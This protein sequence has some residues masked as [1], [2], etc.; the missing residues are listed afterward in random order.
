MVKTPIR[1]LLIAGLF[2]T[3]WRATAVNAAQVPPVYIDSVVAI[4]APVVAQNPNGA[5]STTWVTE[6]TGFFYG[7][8]AHDDPDPEKRQYE[9]YLVTARHVV[10]GHIA[11][12]KSDLHIRLNPKDATKPDQ[13]FSLPNQPSPGVAPWF[14]HPN[15]AV[16]VAIIQISFPFLR[17]RGFYPQAF[18]N[19]G[20]VA[21]TK[22]LKELEVAAGDGVFVLGF[23]MNLAGAL[24]NYVI[25]R[26]GVIARISEMLDK[27]SPT[28]LIDAHVFPGNSGGPVVLRADLNSIAGTRIQDH[29][30]L[31]G[32]VISYVP[33]NDAAFSP[34]TGQQRVLFQENSGLAEVV[35]VDYIEEAISA[36]RQVRDAA[37]H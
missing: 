20:M 22:K 3:L 18:A 4:G 25:V 23:P 37:K 31:I 11:N 34:Q 12:A 32:L 33:Y 29:A 15:R 10:E 26:Q 6:G 36:W 35:P 19:S 1:R 16:D 2:C 9:T 8:L 14:F 21:D 7:Y 30:Y 24:K 27:A 17:E 5:S 28:F 13:E